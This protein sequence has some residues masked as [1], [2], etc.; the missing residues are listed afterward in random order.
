MKRTFKTHYLS[1][2]QQD[3]P[4]LVDLFEESQGSPLGYSSDSGVGSSLQGT[5]LM[6]KDN[7]T[8]NL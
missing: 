2:A 6:S 3:V 4:G 5:R 1:S 7:Q 8:N